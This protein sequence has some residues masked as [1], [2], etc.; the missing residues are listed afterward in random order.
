MAQF[1]AVAVGHAQDSRLGQEVSD[2]AGLGFQPAEEAGAVGQ[3]GEEA[4][5]VVFEPVVEGTL[6]DVFH[7]VEHTDGDQFADGK[8]GLRVLGKI[9]QGVV[10]LAVE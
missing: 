1:N 5:I 4:A 10:Y 2:P 8:D 6:F 9:G 3:F 7:G